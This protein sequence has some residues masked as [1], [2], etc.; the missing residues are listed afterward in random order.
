MPSSY[1]HYRFGQLVLPRISGEA[2]KA[3]RHFPQLFN[4]GLHGPDIFF[5]YNPVF[6]TKIGELGSR[7]HRQSG[8]EF[9]GHA[10]A[11]L[12]ANLSEGGIAYLYGVLGHYALDSVC[13]PIVNDAASQG[14]CGHVELETE[15]DRYLLMQDGRLPPHLQDCSSHLHLTSGERVTAA[16]FYAPAGPYAVGWSV[17][18]MRIVTHALASP[19]RQRLNRIFRI[20]GEHASQMV[21]LPHA[22]QKCAPLNEV[23]MAHYNAALERFPILSEQLAAALKDGRP[24]G[25]DFAPSFN[26]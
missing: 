5:Y 1:A 12:R 2:G 22:N 9:F 20:A 6:H 18:S 21:M 15:F 3:V 7:F 8:Q 17:R 4:V 26:G 11:T 13:H 10:A 25:A 19:N 23:L 24:L 16:Q 14:M